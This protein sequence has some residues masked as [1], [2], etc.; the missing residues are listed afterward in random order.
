M[1][2]PYIFTGSADTKAQIA[3][4]LALI[5]ELDQ[6]APL[7]AWNG[8]M[9]LHVMISG[10]NGTAPDDVGGYF[11][12][13]GNQVFLTRKALSCL[14]A[15]ARR[16]TVTTAPGQPMFFCRNYFSDEDVDK[17]VRLN[18]GEQVDGTP[19]SWVGD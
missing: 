9:M 11:V 7:S 19:H 16:V 18:Y 8:D 2:A 13:R 17:E 12:V 4:L 14:Y 5:D 10:R 15:D 6:G 3:K 1:K